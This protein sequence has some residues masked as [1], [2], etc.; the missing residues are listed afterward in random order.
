MRSKAV[1]SHIS[2]AVAQRLAYK[3]MSNGMYYTCTIIF[4]GIALVGAISI[5]DV[6]IVFDFVSAIS[7]SSIAFFIPATFY[8]LIAKNE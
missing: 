1:M 8:L 7:V 3:D 6:A 5:P 2:A 4:Y